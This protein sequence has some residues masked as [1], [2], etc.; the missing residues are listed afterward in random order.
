VLAEQQNN[1]AGALRAVQALST[2]VAREDW[3]TILPAYARC[4]RIT[5]DQKEIYSIDPQLFEDATEKALFDALLKAESGQ[6]NA[7][8]V[9]DTLN[10]FVPMIP[11]V[12][13][14]FDSVLVMAE[15]ARVRGN[16]LGLLQRIAALTKGVADLT[17]LEEF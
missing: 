14:F 12:N 9:A 4:V 2:W 6:K 10:A 3:N 8:S 16:R 5:R 7:G 17:R 11:A 13:A 1:P 15:D